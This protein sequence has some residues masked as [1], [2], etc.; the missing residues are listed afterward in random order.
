[1]SMTQKEMALYLEI[2][3]GEGNT[4]IRLEKNSYEFRV[5]YRNGGA[6]CSRAIVYSLGCAIR[7]CVENIQRLEKKIAAE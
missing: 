3:L 6:S 2:A 7:A 4:D 5:H 1:M